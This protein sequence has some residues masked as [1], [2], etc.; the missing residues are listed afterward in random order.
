MQ[1]CSLFSIRKLSWIPLTRSTGWSGLETICNKLRAF[2]TVISIGLL[3]AATKCSWFLGTIL[4]HGDSLARHTTPHPHSV[5]EQPSDRLQVILLCRSSDGFNYCRKNT[6]PTHR[7]KQG[8]PKSFVDETVIHEDGY[9]SYARP[10]DGEQCVKVTKRGV[11]YYYI[12]NNVYTLFSWSPLLTN[13][14]PHI[15]GPFSSSSVLVL[16]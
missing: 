4:H 2:N 10:D 13:T 1:R 12:K 7:C 11:C 6:C 14:L 3:A 9:V 16:L 5:R 15:T 8:F